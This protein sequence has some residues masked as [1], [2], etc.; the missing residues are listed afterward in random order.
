MPR[1][2]VIQFDKFIGLIKQSQENKK[3]KNKFERDK[4][5]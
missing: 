4:F 2:V 5:Y 3:R 1:L